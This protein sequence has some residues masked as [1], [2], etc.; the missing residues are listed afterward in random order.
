MAEQIKT[1][2]EAQKSLGEKV[3]SLSNVSSLVEQLQKLGIV[4]EN[5][6]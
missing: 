3:D 5:V 6:R 4:N 2:T 1:I